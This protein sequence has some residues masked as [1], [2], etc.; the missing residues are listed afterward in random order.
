MTIKKA[1]RAFATKIWSCT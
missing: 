1:I